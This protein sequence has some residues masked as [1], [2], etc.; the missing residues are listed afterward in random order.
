MPYVRVHVDVGDVMEE[1]EDDALI[2]EMKSRNLGPVATCAD[3][4]QKLWQAF[5]MGRDDRALEIAR[6]LAE[7]ATG[8]LV[9]RKPQL[10]MV[11]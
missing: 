10:R 3:L 1:I 9:P 2:E 5:Y 4:T 7:Q 11:A 8:R 6:E